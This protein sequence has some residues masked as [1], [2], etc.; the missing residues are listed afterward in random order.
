MCQTKSPKSEVRGGVGDAAQA[1]LNG[2][3]GLMHEHVCSVKLLQRAQFKRSV[4]LNWITELSYTWFFLTCSS[5]AAPSTS[6]WQVLMEP[7]SDTSGRLSSSLCH[8]R[9]EICQDKHSTLEKKKIQKC[10]AKHK[11]TT[12]RRLLLNERYSLVGFP[13]RRMGTEQTAS[14]TRTFCTTDYT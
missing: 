12:W 14:T 10:S 1:V 6:P 4:H 5:A 2:V 8:K 7:S 13:S 3:D 11:L 9:Q